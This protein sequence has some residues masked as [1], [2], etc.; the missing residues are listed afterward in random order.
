[1][2]PAAAMS[3][4]RADMDRHRH[5]F[6]LDRNNLGRD[7][8]K[9]ATDGV[10]ATIA[11]EESPDGKRWDELSEEYDEWKSFQF[12]GEPIAVLHQIMADPHQVAGEPPA[13]TADLAE[14]TYGI[15]E[16]AKQEAAWFQ[17]GGNGRPA[18]PFWGLTAASIAESG[19][20]LDARLASI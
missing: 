15:T 17:E 14:V 2:N 1:M 13:V 19:R 10:Q 6:D 3:R 12:P 5:A 16:Q 20:I 9:A 8:C 7:L 18:R 4:I 11:A